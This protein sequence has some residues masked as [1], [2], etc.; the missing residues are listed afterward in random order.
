M[1]GKGLREFSGETG[2]PRLVVKTKGAGKESNLS[3]KV[4]R[5]VRQGQAREHSGDFHNGAE[6]SKVYLYWPLCT[7]NGGQ[8]GQGWEGH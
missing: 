5:R 1:W 8:P 4:D 2:K 6:L 7:E 3:Y